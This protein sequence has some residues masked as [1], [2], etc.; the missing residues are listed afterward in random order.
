[1]WHSKMAV[2]ISCALL[3]GC[4]QGLTQ[5]QILVEQEAVRAQ[6]DRW[7]KAVNN[8]RV[9]LTAEGRTV[10][11]NLDSVYAM[12]HQVDELTVSS[13]SGTVSEGW[14]ARLEEIRTF[15]GNLQYVN[16]V[17]QGP[18]VEVLSP[19]VA[20]TTFGHSTTVQDLQR[21]RSIYAGRG[22]LVWV[23]DPDARLWKIHTEHI[24]SAV[25]MIR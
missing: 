15:Y 9:V 11:Q 16:F 1:M 5:R 2:L 21:E 17:L 24:S 18:S 4:S 23:K 6:L 20:I 25:G 3:V 19:N 22:T 8:V 10:R 7:V 13:P 12:Y 14:E